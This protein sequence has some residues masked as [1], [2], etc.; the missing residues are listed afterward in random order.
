M[1]NDPAM[2]KLSSTATAA[3]TLRAAAPGLAVLTAGERA[4]LREWL[5]RV[6]AP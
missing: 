4:L 1:L 5:D 3:V 6:A 2:S